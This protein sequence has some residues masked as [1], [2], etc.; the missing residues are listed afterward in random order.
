MKRGIGWLAGILGMAVFSAAGAPLYV[1][2][3]GDDT[4][5]GSTWE[6]AKLTIQGALAVSGS[7]IYVSNGTYSAISVTKSVE[8]QGVGG[9]SNTFIDGGNVKTAVFIKASSGNPVLSGFT[10]QNGLAPRGGGVYVDGTA[11]VTI[12]DC[13][14]MNN[15]AT[16]AERAGGG[17]YKYPSGNALILTNCIIVSNRAAVGYGGGAY[18]HYAKLYVHNCQILSNQAGSG[19]G[20]AAGGNSSPQSFEVRNSL[21]AYNS[22]SAAG[23][24]IYSECGPAAFPSTLYDSTIAYN[25]ATSFGGG[26][27]QRSVSSYPGHLSMTNCEIRGNSVSSGP[28]GGL[29]LSGRTHLTSCLIAENTGSGVGGGACIYSQSTNIMLFENVTIASNFSSGASGYGGG[30][31][32][33]ADATNVTFL[34]TII[35]GNSQ[36]GNYAG[37][38]NAY[39][40]AIT[41]VKF[42]NCCVAPV[43][44]VDGAGNIGDD[45]LYVDL[46][47]GDYRLKADSPC[48][49]T[50]TNFDWM[51][52]AL[53][54]DG[55][56]RLDQFSR[57]VDMGAFERVPAGVLMKLR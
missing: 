51:E 22:V 11:N 52:G 15:V 19:G 6:L 30:L 36:Q 31:M 28:G 27:H 23:G 49:N 8:I 5:D 12:K 14:I 13:R 9:Y 53:D 37:R 17:V 3:S 46:A 54:L 33:Y 4:N 47:G 34:N 16:S 21:I 43:S 26:S 55:H 18:S 42:T 48:V 50:G 44:A 20:L 57:Q 56:A 45:P 38:S 29:S 1:A 25:T 35:Y 40:G 24:G 32:T 7:P 39:I 41:S 2:E 10:I